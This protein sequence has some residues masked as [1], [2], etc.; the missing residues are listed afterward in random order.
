VECYVDEHRVEP[1]AGDYY[2]GWITPDVVGPFKGDPGT[3]D[4]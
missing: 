1:Q 2:G 3:G 4:W